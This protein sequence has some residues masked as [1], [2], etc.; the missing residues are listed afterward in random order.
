VDVFTAQTGVAPRAAAMA[1][2][3]VPPVWDA[4]LSA[5]V[6]VFRPTEAEFADFAAYV[7]AIEPFCSAGLAKIIPP[8]G[9]TPRRGGYEPALLQTVKVKQPIAQQFVKH[10]RYAG[11]YHQQNIVKNTRPQWS[12]RNEALS[13]TFRPS[14]ALR[15]QTP[16]APAGFADPP[17]PRAWSPGNKAEAAAQAEA[18]AAPVDLAAPVPA[19]PPQRPDEPD[20]AFQLRRQAYLAELEQQYWSTLPVSQPMYG[21]DMAGSLFDADQD[22]W[23]LQ[24]LPNL[25]TALPRR[26]P[27][28]CAPYLYFGMW[29]ATF[30][31]H[32]EDM[33]LYSINYL[34]YG[35]PKQ[36]YVIPPS[37]RTNFELVA[38]DIFCDEVRQCSQF[39]RHKTQLIA[40]AVLNQFGIPVYRVIQ[41]RGAQTERFHTWSGEGWGSARS[42][43]NGRAPWDHCQCAQEAGHFV[44]T[45]PGAYHAG[46]N[47]GFNCAEAVNFALPQWIP[48]GRRAQWC[49]CTRDAVFMDMSL[50]DGVVPDEDDADADVAVDDA[51]RGA[52]PVKAEAPP[53]PAPTYPKLPSFELPQLD[54]LKPPAVPAGAAAAA[55]T[56]GGRSP[57]HADHDDEPVVPH[58]DGFEADSD[59]GRPPATSSS[60]QEPD[61]APPP[62]KR[63]AS[64]DRLSLLAGE[65]AK[66]P[67][68]D[69]DA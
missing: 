39:M 18:A 36:W 59:S 46:F 51:S 67:M 64:D 3:V 17:A 58:S 9:W 19:C 43:P 38:A 55:A 21:A 16:P 28:V 61:R 30:S 32:V 22:V 12:F 66:R 53:A 41:V 48:M 35:A 10:D 25:L 65:A 27:G 7:T 6:P 50:F 62:L 54:D 63:P 45:F 34:H 14:A 24:R 11:A 4:D 29:R 42:P 23:N 68:V 8:P 49:S 37:A 47:H 26:L 40:P 31:W 56:A 57:A 13:M 33:D 20:E 15:R 69:P 44:I 1:P 5:G 52:S 60:D 2:L